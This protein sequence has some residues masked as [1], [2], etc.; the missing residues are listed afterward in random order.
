MHLAD[1][2]SQSWQ[3]PVEVLK[4]VPEISLRLIEIFS[5]IELSIFF[6]RTE[7]FIG[8]FGA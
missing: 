5:V 1:N 4:P 2:L 8:C 3:F 7:S 6:W